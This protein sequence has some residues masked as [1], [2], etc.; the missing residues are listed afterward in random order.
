[1]TLMID[2]PLPSFKPLFASL[3]RSMES[4]NL[5]VENEPSCFEYISMSIS[6]DPT[7]SRLVTDK[8]PL[9]MYLP[10]SYFATNLIVSFKCINKYV[11]LGS[12]SVTASFYQC[13]S[14]GQSFHKYLTI[15]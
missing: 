15:S 11:P 4:S 7:A 9:S 8:F 14:N 12:L 5:A 1:V 10:S 13:Y 3:F 6:S 2:F